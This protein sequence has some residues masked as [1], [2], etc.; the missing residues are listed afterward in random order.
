MSKLLQLLHIDLFGPM[1]TISLG[2]MNYTFVI[3][4][5]CY[6]YFWVLYLK[7]KDKV[8]EIFLTFCKKIQN[9]KDLIF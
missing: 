3:I 6:R 8:I 1:S 4:D 2:G 7:K 9:K 5:D